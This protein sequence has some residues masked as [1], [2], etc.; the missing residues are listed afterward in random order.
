MPRRLIRA[1]RGR[2]YYLRTEENVVADETAEFSAA[3]DGVPFPEDELELIL[4]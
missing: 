4:R 3:I 2:Y 1:I